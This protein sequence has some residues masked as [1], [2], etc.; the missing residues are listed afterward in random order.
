MAQ[1]IE[2]S[3]D[4]LCYKT[5]TQYMDCDPDPVADLCSA[6]R[7]RDVNLQASW[8]A[9]PWLGPIGVEVCPGATMGSWGLKYRR[10][11]WKG[12]L[13]QRFLP[14]H[15]PEAKKCGHPFHLKRGRSGSETQ[16]P[17]QGRD[18]TEEQARCRT[19]S[20]DT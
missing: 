6:C 14:F 13:H 11:I 15:P 2:T 16:T 9:N 10:A 8:R 17:S 4:T 7:E 18:G 20:F 19:S 5:G 1:L 12:Y 3:S